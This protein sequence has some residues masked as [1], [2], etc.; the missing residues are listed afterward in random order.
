MEPEVSISLASIGQYSDSDEEVYDRG[1]KAKKIRGKT[2]SSGENV[3]NKKKILTDCGET[4]NDKE[5]RKVT[6]G[7]NGRGSTGTGTGTNNKISA[8]N[9]PSSSDL[10]SSEGVTPVSAITAATKITLPKEKEQ[11]GE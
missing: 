1:Q 9:N 11:S 10:N 8:D 3:K 5:S 4:K 6:S 7:K 2:E